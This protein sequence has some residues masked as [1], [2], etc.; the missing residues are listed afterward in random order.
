RSETIALFFTCLINCLEHVKKTR[1]YFITLYD[2][3]LKPFTFTQAFP[4]F[5]KACTAHHSSYSYYSYIE[6]AS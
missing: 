2:P 5:S 1:T 4:S 3:S 6:Q